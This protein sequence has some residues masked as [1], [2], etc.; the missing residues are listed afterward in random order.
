[1]LTKISDTIQKCTLRDQ[2]NVYFLDIEKKII[3]DT[4]NRTYRDDL[5]N[6]LGRAVNFEEI[7]IV[8]FTHLHYDHSG[9]YDLFPNAEFYASPEEIDDFRKNPEGSVLDPT[10]AEMLKS[11]TI[12]PLPQEFL[13]LKILKTPGHTRGSICLYYENE[14]TLFSGDTIFQAKSQGRTDLPTSQPDQM[15]NSIMSLIEVPYKILCPGHDY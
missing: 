11:I 9:N 6:F 14:K 13:G 10:V 15:R 7:Q 4:G 12:K 5:K 2:G 8:I 1:M 3:I